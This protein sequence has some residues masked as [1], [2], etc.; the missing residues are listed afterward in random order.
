L[1][2]DP[3]PTPTCI[4]FSIATSHSLDPRKLAAASRRL[5]GLIVADLADALG[6]SVLRDVPATARLLGML[7]DRFAEAAGDS[8]TFVNAGESGIPR[9]PVAPGDDVLDLALG[10]A[11]A[12]VSGRVTSGPGC[13]RD[14]AALL[15]LRGSIA[16]IAGVVA[17][18]SQRER[19]AVG[20]LQMLEGVVVDVVGGMDGF[21]ESPRAVMY[22][23]PRKKIV[24]FFVFQVLR[25]APSATCCLVMIPTHP[26]LFPFF[27][28][29]TQR[30]PGARRCRCR[31]GRRR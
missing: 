12:L 8:G 19:M 17:R 10:V 27:P 11:V 20:L 30:P 28:L 4:R 23:S 26:R 1:N 9:A 29:S 22:I 31:L 21:R 16:R 5:S 15:A 13:L 25:L 3:N 7:F 24:S 14:N 18:G 6:P 2:I